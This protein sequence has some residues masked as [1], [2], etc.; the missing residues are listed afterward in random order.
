[1]SALPDP[2]PALTTRPDAIF[3]VGV[4]YALAAYVWWGVVAIY[5]KAVAHVPP[6]VTLS[7]R[8]V[9]SMVLLAVLITFTRQWPE[10]RTAFRSRRLIA[11]LML[12]TLLVATNWVVFIYAIATHRLVEASLGYFINPLVTVLLGMLFL[13]E[14]LRPA[15]WAAAAISFAGIVYLSA[16]RGGLPWITVALPLSFASYSLI[17]KVA[18]VSALIG[19]FVETALLAPIAAVYLA[20]RHAAPDAGAINT[21][22]TLA[23]LSLAGVVTAVPLLWFVAAARRLSMVTIG[24]MQFLNPTLQFLTAVVLFH[25]PFDNDRLIAFIFVW[26]A[27]VVFIVDLAARRRGERRSSVV[28]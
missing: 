23:L 19:L 20:I 18:P 11:W 6:F 21:T 2:T 22:S 25:E 26:I 28:Q 24:F 3:R 8:I 15:Q 10:V 7:H 13:H 17:R 9:W 27:V 12:S 4:A 16:S 14:R 5:F 1:M